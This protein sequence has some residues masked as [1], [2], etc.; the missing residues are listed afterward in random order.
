MTV[1]G[2]LFIVF[3]LALLQAHERP[4]WRRRGR[5]ETE[6]MMVLEDGLLFRADLLPPSE[7]HRV[8][9][10]MSTLGHRWAVIPF[11]DVRSAR[12]TP[13][14]WVLRHGGRRRVQLPP[15]LL[16]GLK[17]DVL[18]HF[19]RAWRAWKEAAP[20]QD[21]ALFEPT[22]GE[23]IATW[24]TRC[25][26]L[27]GRAASDYR[28]AA[29]PVEA[30]WRVVESAAARPLA[31]IGAVVALGFELPIG[32]ATESCTGRLRRAGNASVSPHFRTI[33]NAQRRAST[34]EDVVRWAMR[35]LCTHTKSAYDD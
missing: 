14:G 28:G 25:R 31:R 11:R 26:A 16:E 24:F 33:C 20:P 22:A 18:E 8:N 17:T 3:L 29:L 6:P 1:L 35:E 27:G 30:I 12:M 7:S 34:E 23:D 21:A 15:H 9:E 5:L 10:T 19:D 13:D 32:G 4:A 2:V